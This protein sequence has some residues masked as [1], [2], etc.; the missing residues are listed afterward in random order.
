[1]SYN[2]IKANTPQGRERL[3]ELMDKGNR[4]VGKRQGQLY[5]LFYSDERMGGC[6]WI[7]KMTWKSLWNDVVLTNDF[8]DVEFLDPEPDENGLLQTI[9]NLPDDTSAAYI[10]SMIH[11]QL[12]RA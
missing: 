7:G 5:E 4:V 11:D 12:K 2:W 10:K 3:I 8:I 1:M 9:L 6:Y